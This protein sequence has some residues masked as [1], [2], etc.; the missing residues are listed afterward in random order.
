MP[1]YSGIID[2]IAACNE[3]GRLALAVYLIHGYPSL[4]QS[5]RAYEIVQQYPSMMI[6]CGLP[7]ADLSAADASPPIRESHRVAS[8]AGLSDEEMLAFYAR[9]RPNLLM[10]QQDHQR[11]DFEAL[12]DLIQGSVDAVLTDNPAFASVL[13]QTASDPTSP[14]VMRFAS[15]LSETPE[16]TVDKHTRFI[17]LGVASRTGGELLPSEQIQRAADRVT[18]AAPQAKILCG[19]GIR[20]VDD[21]RRISRI[22]GVHALVIGT[23]AMRRLGEG[24]PEF[25]R[26]LSD[27]DRALIQEPY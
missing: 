1:T 18:Q 15:A 16:Q 12:R 20:T 3:A 24:L 23:E 2:A 17:Y 6:E 10:H 13:S 21:V 25:E 8:Q 9:Y 11:T 27:I 14:L 19:L 22:R 4:E 7:V 26:W 5:Q